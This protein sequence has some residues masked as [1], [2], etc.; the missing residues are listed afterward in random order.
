M[1]GVQ[2]WLGETEKNLKVVKI[3]WRKLLF[4]SGHIVLR[5]IVLLHMKT[6]I[7]DQVELLCLLTLS[8]VMSSRLKEVHG[9]GVEKSWYSEQM[10]VWKSIDR[11]RISLDRKDVKSTSD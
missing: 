3:I 7:V 2:F 8:H 5:P 11:F 10:R 6:N 4:E 9:K 1:N